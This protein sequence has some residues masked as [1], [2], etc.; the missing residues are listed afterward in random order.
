MNNHFKKL[1]APFVVAAVITGY[2]VFFIW[3][4][5]K[6]PLPLGVRIAGIGIPVIF[7]GVVIYVLIERIQEIRKGEEDDLSQ[8]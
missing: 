5:I 7:T 6:F 1:I 2:Y 3:L 8:Y 4:I